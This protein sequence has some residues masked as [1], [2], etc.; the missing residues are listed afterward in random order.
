MVDGHAPGRPIGVHFP[1]DRGSPGPTAT[2]TGMRVLVA[3][4]DAGLKSVL[5]R[6]LREA[7][8]VVDAVADGNEA[9]EYLRA[10]E[11]TASGILDWRM[12]G[13]SGFEVI[14]WGAAA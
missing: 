5:E 11:Y 13:A 1:T 7:G 3:E 14:T 2:L 8:Y 6:G 4:D 9:I 12:P 10:Y